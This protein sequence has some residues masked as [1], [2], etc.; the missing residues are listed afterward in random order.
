M[1]LLIDWVEQGRVPNPLVRWGI[2]QLLARRLREERRVHESPPG[3]RLQEFIDQLRASPIAL[4]TDKANEQHYE[5]PPAFFQQVLGARLKYSG[6]YWAEGVTTLS[7]AEDA[8]LRLSCERARLQDGMAILDLGC[9]WGSLSFWIAEHYPQCRIL[10]VSNSRGQ[11]EFIQSECARRGVSTIEVVTADINEFHTD[12]RFHR[13]LSVEMFEHLRN[14]E[15]LLARIATWLVAEGKLFVHIFCHREFAYPFETHGDDNWM[16]R[17]FFTGGIMPSDDLLLS[18][19]RDLILE[20]RWRVNGHHYART[21]EAWLMNLDAQRPHVLP[22]LRET[23]GAVEAERWF[24]RWRLFFLA[25]AELFA[26][27]HGQEWWVS[28]YLFGRHS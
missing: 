8:M 26:Y 15:H 12:R 23:Y 22:I 2:R 7:A 24:H 25:C 16:G 1:S 13:V 17:Y 9:G 27:H 18:F 5:V 20:E 19:Q 10:A 11:R 28:H 4:H 3:E 14:Y 6:C 21:A